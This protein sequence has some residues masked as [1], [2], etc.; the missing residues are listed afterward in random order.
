MYFVLKYNGFSQYTCTRILVAIFLNVSYSDLSLSVVLLL[1]LTSG[2]FT[3]PRLDSRWSVVGPTHVS[4]LPAF[5]CLR[6]PLLLSGPQGVAVHHLRFPAAEH[7]CCCSL[8]PHVSAIGKGSIS[9]KEMWNCLMITS[10]STS[11]C[12][13]MLTIGAGVGAIAFAIVCYQLSL[14][15]Q[16]I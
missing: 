10:S 1:C 4:A 2:P 13:P 15:V 3:E 11:K 16:D 12:L 5:C 8:R 14:L 6:L 9:F 7:Y